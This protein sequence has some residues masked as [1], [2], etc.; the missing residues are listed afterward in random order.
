MLKLMFGGVITYLLEH[1]SGEYGLRQWCL[2]FNPYGQ[3]KFEG[4]ADGIASR[5]LITWWK[6]NCNVWIATRVRYL[7]I[8]S[9]TNELVQY[10]VIFDGRTS[11]DFDIVNHIYVDKRIRS[12]QHQIAEYPHHI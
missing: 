10:R 1:S 12:G 8:S 4:E 11:S 2:Y 6:I 3:C 5:S 9:S 7:S